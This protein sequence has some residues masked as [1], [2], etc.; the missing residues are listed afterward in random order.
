MR[1]KASSA[2]R[3]P[4]CLG[5]N[6]LNLGKENDKEIK[7]NYI[8]QHNPCS[9]SGGKTMSNLMLLKEIK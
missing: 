2:K 6:E 3:R 9:A 4:F 1:L 8:Q 5:L 7:G